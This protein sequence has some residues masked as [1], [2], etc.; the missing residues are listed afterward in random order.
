MICPCCGALL[1][2][3][4]TLERAPTGTKA[5]RASARGRF[6]LR[7]REA[8]AVDLAIDGLTN[9]EISKEMGFKSLQVV[10]NYLREAYDKIGCVNRADMVRIVLLG[11][12]AKK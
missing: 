5:F 12:E 4:L 8:E 11:R 2:V 9:E 3:K 7:K 10:K 1:D 6:G